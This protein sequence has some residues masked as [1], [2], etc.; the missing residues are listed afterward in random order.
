MLCEGGVLYVFVDH[1]V[2]VLNSRLLI[3]YDNF[4]GFFCIYFPLCITPGP[5]LLS[6]TISVVNRS[7]TGWLYCVKTSW[8]LYLEPFIYVRLKLYIHLTVHLI[9]SVLL[10]FLL[11]STSRV[12]WN[13]I[14]NSMSLGLSYHNCFPVC[15]LVV[16]SYLSGLFLN[17]FI[18][19]N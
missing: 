13:K 2:Y 3:F 5:D 9:L 4:F 14:L 1:F 7:L 6:Y 15:L 19:V 11:I 17:V 18:P 16:L 12:W 8:R 10:K